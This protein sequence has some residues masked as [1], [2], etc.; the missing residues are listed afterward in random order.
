[1]V[2]PENRG[3]LY[4]A[5]PVYFVVLGVVAFFSYRR[6][7]ILEKKQ[8]NDQCKLYQIVV[9]CHYGIIV[10][11]IVYRLLFIICCLG[12]YIILTL[13]LSCMHI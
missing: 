4:V 11:L 2:S 7:R 8:A 5:I 9:C 1:M 3:G 6:A 10:C 13:Y 12:L